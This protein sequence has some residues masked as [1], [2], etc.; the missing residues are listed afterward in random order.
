MKMKRL[1]AWVIILCMCLSIP[2]PVQGEGSQEAHSDANA[3]Q[4]FLETDF[5]IPWLLSKT[6]KKDKRFM[7]KKQD[8]VKTSFTIYMVQGET[9]LFGAGWKNADGLTPTSSEIILYSPSGTKI[10]PDGTSDS[11]YEMGNMT[12]DVTDAEKAALSWSTETTYNPYIYTAGETG[13]YTLEFQGGTDKNEDGRDKY[14]LYW[15]ATVVQNFQNNTSDTTFAATGTV[16][17]GRMYTQFLS[18]SAGSGNV[19]LPEGSVYYVLTNDGYIYS[20][21]LS[22]I[23]PFGFYM[24]SDAQGVQFADI[25]TDESD[26]QYAT[27][28]ALHGSAYQSYQADSNGGVNEGNQATTTGDFFSIADESEHYR[29]FFNEPDS[30]LISA[31]ETEQIITRRPAS[32]V[33]D[34]TFRFNDGNPM[35]Q[36]TGGDFTFTSNVEGTYE[37]TIDLTGYTD[38]D[39]N[40][41]GKVIL[42]GMANANTPTTVHWDGKDANGNIVMYRKGNKYSASMELKVGEVHLP[43]I[44]V[45]YFNSGFQLN[46]LENQVENYHN[47]VFYNNSNIYVDKAMTKKGTDESE[48]GVA[49]TNIFQGIEGD[50][51]VIDLWTYAKKTAATPIDIIVDIYDAKGTVTNGSFQGDSE[52]VPTTENY[53]GIISADPHCYLPDKIKV[54]IGEEEY[55]IED[56]TPVNGI[57][58][59]KDTGKVTIPKEEIDGDIRIIAE[60]VGEEIGVTVKYDEETA[61]SDA[62]GVT[63]VSDTQNSLKYRETYEATILP[64]DNCGI[65]KFEITIGTETYTVDPESG[66]VTDQT[67]NVVTDITYEPQTGKLVIEGSKTTAE[68]VIV[69][70]SEPYKVTDKITN[71]SY[72]GEEKVT[73][74][75]EY[76]GTITPNEDYVL[77]DEITVTIGEGDEKKEYTVED[78]EPKDGITYDKD[79]GKVTISDDKINGDI[80]IQAEC[81]SNKIGVTV[82]YDD[83]TTASD[84]SGVKITSKEEKTWKRGESY[85]AVIE[86]E[87]NCKITEF[88]ITI[89]NETYTVDPESGK[90]TDQNG[91][92]VT[93]I[94]Y[95]PQTG[96]LVIEGSKTTDDVI[97]EVAAEPY[98]VTVDVENGTHDGAETVTPGED[99][100]V[101]ITPNENHEL[102]EEINVTIG[103]N[104]YSVKDDTPTENGITYDQEEG[105]VTIPSEV[106]DGDVTIEATCNQT[107]M[108]SG[109][110]GKVESETITVTVIYDDETIVT[111]EDGV[112]IDSDSKDTMYSGE[113]Y[114]ATVL[115]KENHTIT[116]FE[117]TIED[118]QYTVDPK[119]GVVT[120]TAGNVVT[121]ITYDPQ[122]G[123]LV[124][125]GSKT[126]GKIVITV[127]SEPIAQSVDT[128]DHRY[129]LL[130][131]ILLLSGFVAFGL[132]EI[133][134][135]SVERINK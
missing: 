120:D 83:E 58:Y 129:P 117:I 70:E 78:G 50:G 2:L 30:A 47:L 26:V 55:I 24:F 43:M 11:A 69:A 53:E 29:I 77:P 12:G 66:K 16:V 33:V 116:K 105:K 76:V 97:I 84:S 3:T 123:K 75:E 90:V 82:I 42:R 46:L 37:I 94:T 128:G 119:T 21:D 95:E 91:N 104:E 131:L 4:A 15:D 87:D 113:D 72:T 54:T 108:E 51:Q 114:T 118:S 79:T 127:E 13:F 36:G 73:P 71:G 19:T 41:G 62:G 81:I 9:L 39:G 126:T 28:D 122:T 31:L 101:V 57:T 103:D 107:E 124:I 68:V 35:Y 52:D 134:R 44:D 32:L 110:P 18:M 64:K 112:I 6:L 5:Q 135:Q 111:D 20:V 56:G 74:G 85:E 132:L 48:N 49:A 1:T 115:P 100:I 98:K 27:T 133:K 34:P 102:P 38:D 93:D 23:Q 63:I 130:W 109:E 25:H 86:A 22:G 60:C 92:V 10:T 125:K 45:E 59:D 61:A 88:K 7:N 14:T 65:T 106:V 17:N 67:G 121:D 99:Y 89:G 80:H 96:K 8:D 40:N